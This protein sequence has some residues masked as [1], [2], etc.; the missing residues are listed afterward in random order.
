MRMGELS[1]RT[2]VPIPTIKF[3][4]REG[5][6]SAGE[7]TSLNQAR[8]DEDHVRR[9]KLIRALV[10]VGRLSVAATRAVLGHLDDA[11]GDTLTTLGKVHYALMPAREAGEDPA[12][13]DAE[14]RVQRLVADRGWRVRP[15]NPALGELTEVVAVLLRLGQDDVL[16]LLET[17]ADAARELAGA[18]VDVVRGRELLED[19][20]EGVVVVTALGDTLLA[21]V[22]RLAQEDEVNRW[23]D[24]APGADPPVAAPDPEEPD[25]ATRR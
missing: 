21:A 4:L 10:D 19:R 15:T 5:L 11:G 9:L 18:E 14:E 1:G 25:P 12:W 17:Y 3:Y 16:P 23:L 22:R 7:R 6:L 2:G 8:Y 20:A 13:A 24:P